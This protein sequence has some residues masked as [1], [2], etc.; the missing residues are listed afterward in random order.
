MPTEPEYVFDD[1][2]PLTGERTA[3][4]IPEEN[5]WFQR[6]VIAYEW[7]AARAAGKRVLDAGCGEGYGTQILAAK[8]AEV[9]GVD[10]EAGVVERAAARYP[11][12][13]FEPADLEAL[14]YPDAS[15]DAVVSLQVIEHMRSPIEFCS[16]VARVLRPGGEFLCATPN[17]LTFSP[18][19]IRN[20]FH[21]VE[22][23]P[24]ELRGTL[25]RHF[26]VVEMLGTFH[27]GRI[28]AGEI[29][30]RQSFP[31]RLI[32]TPVPSWSPRL[33]AAV[34]RITT[35]DFRIRGEN[36]DRSLD[37]IAVGRR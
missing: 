9:V 34:A 15:F 14:P 6:H 16:E 23:S 1:A 26:T 31:E 10:L 17:R 5:Y 8:A 24:D 29:A 12:A 22:F 4:G 7:A 28:R 21:T 33:R 3:P 37:L 18:E 11:S 32:E 13:R 20:P 25:G 30:T 2:I 35:R 36:L 19:G 27:A